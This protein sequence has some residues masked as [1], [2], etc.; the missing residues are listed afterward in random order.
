VLTPLN[1]IN[2]VVLVKDNA[3]VYSETGQHF[4]VMLPF[5][6]LSMLLHQH[7]LS[8]N[9]VTVRQ[10]QAVTYIAETTNWSDI[11]KK[12]RKRLTQSPLRRNGANDCTQNGQSDPLSKG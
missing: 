8:H 2:R 5:T 3:F 6:A 12:E 4:A 11:A 1:S 10:R 9:T 7:C